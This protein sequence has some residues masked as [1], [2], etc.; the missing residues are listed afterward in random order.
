MAPKQLLELVHHQT[1]LDYLTH[2]QALASVNLDI[3]NHGPT[4]ERLLRKS[5]LELD[6]GNPTA[7]LQAAHDA[8]VAAPHNPESHYQV[9]IAH[10]VLAF[11]RAGALPTAQGG[12]SP[13]A[14]ATDLLAGAARSFGEAVRLNT[15]DEEAVD[16]LAV[17]TLFLAEHGDEDVLRGA[18]RDVAPC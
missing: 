6:L 5:I 13:S 17:V 14:S 15:E 1:D 11:V 4:A 3:R 2:F 16:D 10:V 12:D 18:L 8:V 9:G 7:A